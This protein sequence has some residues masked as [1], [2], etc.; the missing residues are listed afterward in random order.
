MLLFRWSHERSFALHK[1]VWP[2]VWHRWQVQDPFSSC[3]L[4]LCCF[5]FETSS[6]SMLHF[7]CCQ[8][9]KWSAILTQMRPAYRSWPLV[10]TQIVCTSLRLVSA[11]IARLRADWSAFGKDWSNAFPYSR[12]WCYCNYLVPEVSWS[13]NP[14]L[15][16]SFHIIQTAP[17][18]HWRKLSILFKSHQSFQG[19][20]PATKS[21]FMLDAALNYAHFPTGKNPK[22]VHFQLLKS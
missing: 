12:R 17:A 13:E 7:K 14:N 19:Q 4:G 10:R 5:D 1:C 2:V 15:S 21:I 8:V 20:V 22:F 6:Q 18:G 9:V 16:W 11:A 3:P